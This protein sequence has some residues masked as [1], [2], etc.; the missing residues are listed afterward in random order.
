MDFMGLMKN[1]TDSS[2]F[3]TSKYGIQGVTASTNSDV[4]RSWVANEASHVQHLKGTGNW[5][6]LAA[7]TAH[8]APLRM[9]CQCVH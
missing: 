2:T 8:G 6:S 5:A 3:T 7:S 1:I 9:A 4:G